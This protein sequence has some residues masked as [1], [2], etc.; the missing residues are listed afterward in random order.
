MKNNLKLIPGIGR[1]ILKETDNNIPEVKKTSNIDLGE[2]APTNPF[3]EFVVVSDMNRRYKQGF[4]V[5]TMKS[6]GIDVEIEGVIYTIV[7]NTDI[8]FGIEN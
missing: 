5:K 6:A 1:I 7:S 8:L 2:D 4:I 3:R